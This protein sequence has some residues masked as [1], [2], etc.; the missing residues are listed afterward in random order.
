MVAKLKV[1]QLETVDGT[2]IITVNNPLAGD[3]SSLTALDATAL[4][5][6][7]PALSGASLTALNASNLGSGTVPTARLGTGTADGD[8]FLRG[9]GAWEAV[10]GGIDC[11]ADSWRTE[12]PVTDQNSAAVVDFSAVHHLGS[13]LTES[14][15]RITVGTAGWYLVSF[16]FSNLSA[17]PDN[18]NVW[19][20]KNTTRQAGA[21]YWEGNTE[22]K[23]LGMDATMLVKCSAGAI[24]DIYGSGYWTGNTNGQGHTWFIGTRLGA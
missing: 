22:I 19:L 11:D 17:Y 8:S 3:G 12:S 14:G 6:N 1:D 21:I 7:L 23:Y 13:N 9:D 4:T 24:L 5:G 18:M 10:G 16:H 20:R 15:G 2:G